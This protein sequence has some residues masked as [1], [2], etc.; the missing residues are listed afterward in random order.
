MDLMQR[1]IARHEHMSFSPVL[2]SSFMRGVRY[3][4]TTAHCGID[5]QTIQIIF[6]ILVKSHRFRRDRRER[7]TAPGA[8]AGKLR[9]DNTTKHVTR[10]SRS[11][12]SYYVRGCKSPCM[13]QEA[14]VL[15]RVC[16]GDG[17][18]CS[19]SFGCLAS[20]FT[21]QHLRV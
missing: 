3:G 9:Y 13:R 10:C 20:A 12:Y 8:Y 11:I 4:E 2:L 21:S 1:S 14:V 19:G 18:L 17:G 7:S 5:T 6:N 15:Q 16:L